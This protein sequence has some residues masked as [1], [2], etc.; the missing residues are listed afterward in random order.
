MILDYLS[1]DEPCGPLVRIYG[2]SIVELAS[3]STIIEQLSR[4]LV[5]FV[6]LEDFKFISLKGMDSFKMSVGKR[7]AVE[8]RDSNI[9]WINAIEGWSLVKELLVPF[10]AAISDAGYHQWLAGGEAVEPLADTNTAI[11][12]TDSSRGYW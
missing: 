11:V 4:S 6:G 9:E 5:P 7:T 8:A 10:T 12:I 2:Y 3:F 1:D